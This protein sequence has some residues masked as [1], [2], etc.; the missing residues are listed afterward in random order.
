MMAHLAPLVGSLA[1]RLLGLVLLVAAW[2]KAIDPARFA[3]ELHELWHLPPGVAWLGALAVVGWEA[4]LGAA[5]LAGWRATLVL[6][7]T[8]ATFVVF[9]AVVAWQLVV[10]SESGAS[11]GCFGMLLERTPAQ[12]LA[13]DVLLLA[14]SGVAWLRRTTTATAWRAAVAVVAAIAGVAFALAAPRLAL[15]DH[16]TA[17]APGASLEATGLDQAI[18]ELK[19]G[20]HLVLL[21]D[22]GDP[23]TVAAIGPLNQGLGLPGGGTLVWGLAAEDREA[24]A[25]FLWSAGP[26]FE[27]RSASPAMLRRLYRTLPRSALVDDGRVVATWNGFP[28]ASAQ[29]ALSR[30]EL[31]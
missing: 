6:V 26:A 11:C 20:R 25:A 24:A 27:V 21:L 13:E 2:A 1:A 28:P 22:R 7:A 5:L 17:L 4:G 19:S 12:A 8:T 30:G 31:P 29:A 9:T 3:D 16:A 18:P 15:D 14:L 23:D 10:P